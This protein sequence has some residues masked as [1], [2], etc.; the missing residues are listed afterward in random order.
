[1]HLLLAGFLFYGVRWQTK[2]TD[3]VEVELVRAVAEPAPAERKPPVAK[4]TPPREPRS[5]P[6][7]D[8]TEADRKYVEDLNKTLDRM[9]KEK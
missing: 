1:M 6:K 7:D 3:V 8:G 5:P 4:A 9:L 2:A